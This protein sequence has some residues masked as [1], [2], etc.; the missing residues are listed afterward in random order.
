MRKKFLVLMRLP[1][2]FK[3]VPEQCCTVVP[4]SPTA[5]SKFVLR[6]GHYR[7]FLQSS[8]SQSAVMV[9]LCGSCF[10]FCCRDWDAT[11]D[12]AFNSLL[13]NKFL[14]FLRDQEVPTA[15]VKSKLDVN[16]VPTHGT[17]K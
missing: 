3:H 1:F 15:T 4:T 6:I 13:R 5:S 9:V 11:F 14:P 17:L 8:S 2:M 10:I 12:G 16:S 7:D